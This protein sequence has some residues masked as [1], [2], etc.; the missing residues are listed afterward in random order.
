MRAHG[1]AV[2]PAFCITTEVCSRFFADPQ[3]SLDWIWEAVREKVGWL[4]KETKRTFGRGPRP[5]LVSVRSGAA[6]SMPGML[7]TVLVLGIDDEVEDALAAAGS[8]EFARD[9]R[10]RFIDMYRR[11][12]L[13]GNPDVEVRD[14]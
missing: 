3:H 7:D 4:E 8:A 6:Q 2:P 13:G 14:D 10:G 11:I 5:L 1:L 9:T 12:V